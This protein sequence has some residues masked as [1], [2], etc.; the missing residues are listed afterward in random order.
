VIYRVWGIEFIKSEWLKITI[1]TILIYFF[2]PLCFY[3][4]TSYIEDIRTAKEREKNDKER[5]KNELF[6]KAV[7]DKMYLNNANKVELDEFIRL[8]YQDIFHSSTEDAIKFADKLIADLEIKKKKL[9]DLKN[10]SSIQI[11]KLYLKWRPFFD[12][13]LSALDNRIDE[14]SKKDKNIQ[15]DKN[16]SSPIVYDVD[17]VK[18][19]RTLLRSLHI[20]GKSSFLIAYEPGEVSE[21][22]CTKDLVIII[23]KRGQELIVFKFTEESIIME[24]V[25]KKYNDFRAS[26]KTDDPLNETN[27]REKTIEAINLLISSAYISR[28]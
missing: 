18:Y 10:N 3:L 16:E 1:E 13:F 9:G 24:P 5:E 4:I 12:F 11:N 19:I 15:Y 8:K 26:T 25:Y 6:Q 2:L 28:D 14:L 27:L 7:L 23:S 17:K 22:I 20:D 21:G